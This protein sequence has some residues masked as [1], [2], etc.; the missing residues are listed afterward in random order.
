MTI[1][2]FLYFAGVALGVA[3][4]DARPLPRIAMALLWPVGIAAF[5]VTL[6]ILFV[7]AMIAFPLFGAVLL[8]A[9]VALWT[10]R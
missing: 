5:L 10:L 2:A 7:A 4:G 9:S 8:A 3:L 1:A 6:S